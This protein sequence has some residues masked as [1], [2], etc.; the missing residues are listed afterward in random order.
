[1]PLSPDP[2]LAASLGRQMQR[3]P[4]LATQLDAPEHM[5]IQ[6]VSQSTLMMTVTPRELAL[7]APRLSEVE[8][9]KA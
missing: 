7:M 1:M 9:G 6:E 8:G 2:R 3:A 5:A 4:G